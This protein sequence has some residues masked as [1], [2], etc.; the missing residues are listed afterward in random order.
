MN[1]YK[2]IILTADGTLGPTGY[3]FCNDAAEARA[4]AGR[5]LALN[6]S[7]QRVQVYLDDVLQFEIDRAEF[8][9]G[10]QKAGS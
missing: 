7:H 8:R 1:H 4:N 5:L 3:V 6:P 9:R 10:I 2:L